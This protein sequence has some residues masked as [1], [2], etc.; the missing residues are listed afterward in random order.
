MALRQL[1]ASLLLWPKPL[2]L[3][4]LPLPP[5]LHRRA[6]RCLNITTHPHAASAAAA[7][8]PAGTTPSRT[9]SAKRNTAFA[10]HV[11]LRA[12]LLSLDDLI[13]EYRTLTACADPDIVATTAFVT[14]VSHPRFGRHGH[15]VALEAARE[16]HAYYG[17]APDLR[18][19]N[20]LLK[21][22]AQNDDLAEIIKTVRAIRTLQANDWDRFTLGILIDACAKRKRGPNMRI[23]NKLVELFKAR[24]IALP[25]QVQA[26]ILTA[27]TRHKR[28]NFG[29]MD[30]PAILNMMEDVL[31]ETADADPN[32]ILYSIILNALSKS[33]RPG[34]MMAWFA[35]MKRLGI[36]DHAAYNCVITGLGLSGN[37]PRMVEVYHQLMDELREGLV[38]S[39]SRKE[40][41]WEAKN[42]QLLEIERKK[43]EEDYTRI[44]ETMHS[45]AA[46]KQ[47]VVTFATMIDGFASARDLGRVAWCYR[48][49][50]RAQ[51]SREEVGLM[52]R[53]KVG[54]HLAEA[55]SHP[56]R[57]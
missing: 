25:V 52:R 8:L 6:C 1:G 22:H 44:V 37:L 29:E 55:A 41:D 47:L 23:L 40:A 38:S 12:S 56:R 42:A 19:L 34:K 33:E 43:D 46:H 2:L 36:C 21:M 3:P 24:G 45:R 39:R 54:G 5:R 10:R 49:M 20:V 15:R 53:E 30:I 11:A 57:M 7:A 28:T 18:L 51:V 14:A 17:V 32:I 4:P 48:E 16:L 35:L 9:A 26:S 27:I 13:A 50:K 31:P